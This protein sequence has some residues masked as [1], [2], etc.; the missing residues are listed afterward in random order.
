M[1]R[2]FFEK[3]RD[4]GWKQVQAR[5]AKKPFSGAVKRD[6]QRK[7][8]GVDQPIDGL[9]GGEVETKNDGE[10]RAGGG[11]YPENGDYADQRADDEA[12]GDAFGRDALAQEP[13]YGVSRLFEAIHVVF[14]GFEPAF[15]AGLPWGRIFGFR[16]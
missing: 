3:G 2:V 8:H 4:F 16:A 6:Q 15:R 5:R 13:G 7:L 11:G 1:P 10:E 9:Y 14:A 12:D